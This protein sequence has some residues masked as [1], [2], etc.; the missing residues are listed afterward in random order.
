[1][2]G[3]EIVTKVTDLLGY[4]DASG[5][6]NIDSVTRKNMLTY[7]NTVFFDI[8]SIESSGE[9]SPLKNLNGD[10]TGLTARGVDALIYGVCMWAAFNAGDGDR[11]AYFTHLYNSK[12]AGLT[13][14][15]RIVDT[16]PSPE[17]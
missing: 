3:N 11:H 17:E 15:S 7:I 16:S 8:F 2:T 14:S 12:R 10:I 6:E 1:M 4:R 5:D 13:G 9:F